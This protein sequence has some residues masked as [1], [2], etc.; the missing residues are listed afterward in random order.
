MSLWHVAVRGMVSCRAPTTLPLLCPQV[1][2]DTREAAYGAA[3]APTGGTTAPLPAV[4]FCTED[5]TLARASAAPVGSGAPADGALALGWGQQPRD[6]GGNSS[7]R[8]QVLQQLPTAINSF[9][10][11]GPFGRDIV[12]VTGRQTLLYTHG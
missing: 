1:R 11:G 12:A 4:L 9:D 10:V 8:H 5:G 6:R 3:D 7:S 2:F